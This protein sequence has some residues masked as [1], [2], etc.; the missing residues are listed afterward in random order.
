MK[1]HIVQRFSKLIEISMNVPQDI[2]SKIGFLSNLFPYQS[3]NY[4]VP[5]HVLAALRIQ[6]PLLCLKIGHQGIVKMFYHKTMCMYIKTHRA[7][8]V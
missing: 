2:K 3:V 8:D 5:I 7:Y 6:Q 1:F 4:S